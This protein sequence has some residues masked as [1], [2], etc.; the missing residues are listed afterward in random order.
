MKTAML[1]ELNRENMF[2]V[3]G[4][5]NQFQFQM[6][7]AH[8]HKMPSCWVPHSALTNQRYD[9]LPI[10]SFLPCSHVPIML[11]CLV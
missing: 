1:G 10:L 9:S 6:M 3:I 8:G 2:F 7:L 5:Q 11:F 4:I